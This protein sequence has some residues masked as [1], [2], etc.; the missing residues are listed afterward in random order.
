MA[1]ERARAIGADVVVGL[2][3]HAAELSFAAGSLPSAPANHMQLGCMS[4]D[5]PTARQPAIILATPTQQ[6]I[7]SIP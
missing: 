6:T 7:D 2:A 5:A 4:S 3:P 1:E